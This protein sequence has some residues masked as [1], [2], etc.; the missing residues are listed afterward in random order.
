MRAQNFDLNFVTGIRE[1]YFV[2]KIEPVRFIESFV[3]SLDW[4]SLHFGQGILQ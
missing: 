3:V 1:M 4:Q 2:L